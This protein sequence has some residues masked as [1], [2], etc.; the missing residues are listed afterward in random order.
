VIK[1]SEQGVELQITDTIKVLKDALSTIDKRTVDLPVQTLEPKV[2]SKDI[3]N[4]QIKQ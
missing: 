2:S 1:E 3:D 4:L